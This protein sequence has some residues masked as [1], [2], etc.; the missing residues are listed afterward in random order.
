MIR[1]YSAEE[2]QRILVVGHVHDWTR[3]GLLTAE[4]TGRIE[5]RLATGLRRTNVFLRAVLGVFTA[6]IVAAATGLVFV[7][8]RITGAAP[9]ALTFAA[10]AIVCAVS[11]EY[12]IGAFRLYRHGIEEALAAAA[13]ALLGLSALAWTESYGLP[14]SRLAPLTVAALA[15]VAVY[16]RFGFVYAGVAAMVLAAMALSELRLEETTRRLVVAL[17]FAAMFAAARVACLRHDDDVRAGEYASLQAA[18]YVGTYLTVNVRLFDVFGAF[19]WGTVARWFYWGSYA[20]VWLIPAAGLYIAVRDRDRILLNVSGIAALVTFTTNKP[21]LGLSRESWDPILLG[22][23]LVVVATT[24]RRWLARGPGGQRGGFT[25]EKILERD[26]DW[27]RTLAT[28]SV[29][30]P[31][32]GGAARPA[33]SPPS[34]FE[35]GRSGGA[36]GGAQ[37]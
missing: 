28:A 16:R 11:A 33:E 26:R 13:A 21:Y 8:F 4:Q 23:L 15:S 22:V 7:W 36:G 25:A 29:A 34:Q 6:L 5:G 31:Q 10:A 24:V 30:W 12:L 27:L 37:Y 18:A 17:A 9:S 19:A 2:E 20:A 3:A 32:D 35:G 1:R 14:A